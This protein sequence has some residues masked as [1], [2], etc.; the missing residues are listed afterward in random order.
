MP[1]EYPTLANA[2]GTTIS[3]SETAPATHDTAGFDAVTES[4]WLKIGAVVNSGGFPR[5]VREFDDVDL[6]D[7]GTMV[8]VQSERMEAVEVEAVYQGSD[9]GQ[10]AIATAS[11]GQTIRWFRWALPNGT[12]V[13]CAGYVTGYGPTAETS[14][15]YVS[16]RF[17]IKPI[18]DANGVG[19]VFGATTP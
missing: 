18:F 4:A 17:T 6:L 12:K 1:A 15:D 16:A 5:A 2:A 8:I 3:I 13:Y 14:A 19:V 11:D 10:D 9:A 7:G